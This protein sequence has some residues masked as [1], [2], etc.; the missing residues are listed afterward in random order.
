MTPIQAHAMHLQTLLAMA[1]M[2][3]INKEQAMEMARFSQKLADEAIAK[4]SKDKK[5]CSK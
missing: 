5:P 3:L 4:Q 1:R 2:G